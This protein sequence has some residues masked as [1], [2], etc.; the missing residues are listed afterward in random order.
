M[1]TQKRSWDVKM[2][3]TWAWWF[4]RMK[5]VGEPQILVRCYCM[6]FIL[7]CLMWRW[8]QS[9]LPSFIIASSLSL[10]T[11][12]IWQSAVGSSVYLIDSAALSYGRQSSKTFILWFGR[13]LGLQE[14]LMQLKTLQWYAVEHASW[15]RQT[16]DQGAETFYRGVRSLPAFDL[17]RCSKQ[18]AHLPAPG[19]ISFALRSCSVFKGL[20][21]G[22]SGSFYKS[23]FFLSSFFSFSPPPSSFGHLREA[24]G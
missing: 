5:A 19:P 14:A 1:I 12:L 24:R 11:C 4:D 18:R 22:C 21:A 10:C 6:L 2:V 15:I 7:S 3:W 17:R 20:L 13:I 9:T 23:L 8:S 16:L